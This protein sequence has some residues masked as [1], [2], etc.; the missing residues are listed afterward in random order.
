MID[1]DKFSFC[2]FSLDINDVIRQEI[3]IT[4]LSNKFQIERHYRHKRN[5]GMYLSFS[6]MVNDAIDDTDS[7]FMIF[8]NPK[9]I[10]TVNDIEFIIEK[11]TTGY[12]FASAVSF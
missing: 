10:P 5:S 2:F 11:L 6:K 8:C 7:E 9:T 1:I 3:E 4:K 12:C